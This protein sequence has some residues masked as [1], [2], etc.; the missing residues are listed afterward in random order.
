MENYLD[1]GFSVP[2]HLSHYLNE[3][4]QT[5]HPSGPSSDEG[6][7]LFF[8]AYQATNWKYGKQGNQFP[9]LYNNYNL[10]DSC[11]T[12]SEGNGFDDSE[13][14]CH[15]PSILEIMGLHLSLSSLVYIGGP[16]GA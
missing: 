4:P 11:G 5:G 3:H 15:Y 2:W 12:L 6:G 13:L 14:N 9:F 8:N 1:Y 10:Y 16:V 7:S